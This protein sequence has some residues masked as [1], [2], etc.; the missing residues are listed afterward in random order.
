[1]NSSHGSVLW[2]FRRPILRVLGI[3]AGIAC[4]LLVGKLLFELAVHPWARSFGLWPTLTG[5][6]SG[7]L[8]TPEGRT[9]V[10]LAIHSNFLWRTDVRHSPY[11]EGRLEWCEANGVVREFDVSGDV[12]DWRGT[13]FHLTL[14]R[15]EPQEEGTFPS[16]LR[17]EWSGDAMEAV[18]SMA[19]VGSTASAEATRDESI[20]SEAPAV[21]YTLRRD[22][23]DAFQ[24]ACTERASP[25]H[26]V[27]R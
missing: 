23:P 6:W 25:A 10:H 7:E 9:P 27:S 16:E 12:D 11:I 15:R 13:R 14:Y 22:G 19:H 17:G 8:I 21:S 26:E 4:A 3:F 5:E 20:T 18:G 1:M 2:H 24:A